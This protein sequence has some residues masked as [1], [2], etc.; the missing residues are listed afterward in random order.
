MI[1]FLRSLLIVL[2][3]K[4]GIINSVEATIASVEVIPEY[5][6]KKKKK[7]NCNLRTKNGG[8]TNT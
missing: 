6:E 1:A 5:P 4:L 2:L 7:S 8:K 3:H